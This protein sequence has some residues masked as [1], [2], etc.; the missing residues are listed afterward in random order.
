MKHFSL[1]E[2]K[3]HCLLGLSVYICEAAIILPVNFMFPLKCLYFF[4]RGKDFRMILYGQ[5]LKIKSLGNCV[6]I[7]I[8]AI[9]M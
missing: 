2:R 3:D 4:E 1:W 6:K 9:L 7:S 5:D 8:A